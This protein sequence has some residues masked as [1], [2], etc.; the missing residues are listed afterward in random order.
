MIYIYVFLASVFFAW[1]AERSKDK[2]VIVLCS[3]ISIL[4]PSLLGGLRAH[5]I[6]VDTTGYGRADAL[7]ALNA[8]NLTYFMENNRCEPGY[9]VLVYVVMKIFGHENWCY[10][11]YQLITISCVYIGCWKHK[12]ITSIAFSMFIF[13]MMFYNNSF[14]IMRQS[15][16]AAII[17]MGF[18][19]VEQKK[20][21]KFAL[22][23]VIAT[24]FH[25][26]A[27]SALVLLA[28]TYCVISSSI[29]ISFKILFNFGTIF[30]LVLFRII[31]LFISR[32]LSAYTGYLLTDHTLDVI[33]G[34]LRFSA[35]YTGAILMLILYHNG[36]LKTLERNK[37]NFHLYNDIFIIVYINAVNILPYRTMLYQMFVS[38]FSFSALPSYVKEKNFKAASAFAVILVMVYCWLALYI[39]GGVNAT[40]P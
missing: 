22:Y 23:V 10:F 35:M 32:Q 13:F 29:N 20:Y 17:F 15:I 12:K 1:L 38:I 9:Q 6:G 30:F 16:A 27:I 26:S 36:A 31:M 37:V 25:K 8:P 14:S 40:W 11:F 24:M 39:L 18:D 19:N 28:G 4:I 2:G 33:N 3:V 21:M 5:G 7:S 34:G